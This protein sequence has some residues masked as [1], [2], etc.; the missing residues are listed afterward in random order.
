[1]VKP[2]QTGED[3]STIETATPKGAYTDAKLHAYTR[4]LLERAIERYLDDKQMAKE[5]KKLEILQVA[6]Q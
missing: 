5:I 6:P 3:T 4:E 2:P 1:M